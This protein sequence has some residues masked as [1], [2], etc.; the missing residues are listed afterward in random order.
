MLA[1]FP[2]GF[3]I[4]AGAEGF[5]PKDRDSIA[6]VPLRGWDLPKALLLGKVVERRYLPAS[7]FSA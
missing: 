2:S 1:L 3:V 6:L 5:L 7:F 4:Q